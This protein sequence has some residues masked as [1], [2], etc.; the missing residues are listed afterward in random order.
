MNFKKMGKNLLWGI[1]AIIFVWW[2]WRWVQ[3]QGGIL[4]AFNRA[5]PGMSTAPDWRYGIPVIRRHTLPPIERPPITRDVEDAMPPAVRPH[6]YQPTPTPTPVTPLPAAPG[7]PETPPNIGQNDRLPWENN[8]LRRE[9][10]SALNADI[11]RIT[12]YSREVANTFTEVARVGGVD[13]YLSVQR[14]RL[15]RARTLPAFVGPIGARPT[16]APP[17]NLPFTG[18]AIDQSPLTPAPDTFEILPYRPR[19]TGGGNISTMQGGLAYIQE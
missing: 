13:N 10:I 16:I 2:L 7:H 18:Q 14:E 3:G 8:R 19:V 17:V 4:A 9:V 6:P 15:T 11:A 5:F 12:R 1:L